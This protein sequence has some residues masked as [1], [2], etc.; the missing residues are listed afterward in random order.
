LRWSNSGG[1]IASRAFVEKYKKT[2]QN[3]WLALREKRFEKAK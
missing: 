1:D 2:Y 3:G